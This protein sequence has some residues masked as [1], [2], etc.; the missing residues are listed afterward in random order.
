M[1]IGLARADLL[2]GPSGSDF[3]TELAVFDSEV[4]SAAQRRV[5]LLVAAGP[6][7]RSLARSDIVE[8][9]VNVSNNADYLESVAMK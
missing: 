7:L 1:L 2:G 9:K 4:N 3:D 5:D 6:A 8:M